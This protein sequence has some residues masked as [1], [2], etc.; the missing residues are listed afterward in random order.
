MDDQHH[1]IDEIESEGIGVSHELS[2][3]QNGAL[4]PQI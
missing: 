3:I 1:V 2:P 4:R